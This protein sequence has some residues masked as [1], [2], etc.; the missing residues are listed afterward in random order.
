MQ[1]KALDHQVSL[2]RIENYCTDKSSG[3]VII[4]TKLLLTRFKITL[5]MALTFNQSKNGIY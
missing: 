3:A 4:R 2:I 1:F 5:S